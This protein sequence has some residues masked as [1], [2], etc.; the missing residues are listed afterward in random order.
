MRERFGMANF[1]WG[2]DGMLVRFSDCPRGLPQGHD[3][4]QHF[5]RKL[6]YGINCQ[7]QLVLQSLIVRSK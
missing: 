1:A 6:F 7:V 2:M 5:G 4:Q 3:A